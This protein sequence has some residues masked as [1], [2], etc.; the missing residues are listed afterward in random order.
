MMP[1][2]AGAEAAAIEAVEA[3]T[4]VAQS[5][6]EDLGAAALSPCAAGVTVMGLRVSAGLRCGSGRRGGGWCGCGGGLLPRRLRL[7]RLWQLD[8]PERLLIRFE[9]AAQDRSHAR[10]VASSDR[11]RRSQPVYLLPNPPFRQ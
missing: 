3:A 5:Q 9:A 7:R 8:L 1:R 6:F 11:L 2:L 10:R 4:A